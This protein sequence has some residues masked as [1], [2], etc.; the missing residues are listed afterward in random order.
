MSHT[1]ARYALNLLIKGL[2]MDPSHLRHERLTAIVE[3][4]DPLNKETIAVRLACPDIT[5]YLAGQYLK[6]YIDEKTVRCYSLASAP[7]IDAHLQRRGGLRQP[8]VP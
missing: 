5:H 8:L 1:Q 6:V 3:Q 4:I 2:T 7:G